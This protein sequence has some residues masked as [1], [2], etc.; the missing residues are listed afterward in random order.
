MTQLIVDF[1]FFDSSEQLDSL[2]RNLVKILN[3]T[4]DITSDQEK[5]IVKGL[6]EILTN[7]SLK[8]NI[9][10]ILK[11]TKGISVTR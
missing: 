8:G 4:I 2:T 11:K 5:E 6:I 7:Q 10:Q 3:S 1:G 9:N